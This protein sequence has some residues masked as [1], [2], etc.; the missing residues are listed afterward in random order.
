MFFFL[1]NT[2]PFRNYSA[3]DW[4]FEKLK[5]SMRSSSKGQLFLRFP[6]NILGLKLNIGADKLT[7]FVFL[8][9]IKNYKELSLKNIN[10]VFTD[11]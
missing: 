10:T 7:W 4:W 1:L 3:D 8:I 2:H 9:K 5:E 6:V 11:P